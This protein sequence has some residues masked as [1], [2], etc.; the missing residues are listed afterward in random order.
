MNYKIVR[1]YRDHGISETIKECLTLQ[2]AQAHCND[3]ET[4]GS[5]WMDVY[6][7]DQN[8][9]VCGSMDCPCCGSKLRHDEGTPASCINGVPDEGNEPCLYC[10]ECG[11]EH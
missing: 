6:A 8:Q 10:E 9:I 7:K 11:Y 5:D 2:Q 4:S 3:P 1:V